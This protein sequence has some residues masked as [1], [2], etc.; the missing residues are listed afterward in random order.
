MSTS[1]VTLMWVDHADSNLRLHDAP[2]ASYLLQPKVA[3]YYVIVEY[4]YGRPAVTLLSRSHVT[5]M[6]LSSLETTGNAVSQHAESIFEGISAR[7][8]G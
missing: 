6:W 3:H 2:P 7:G 5:L 4:V 8:D 1:D